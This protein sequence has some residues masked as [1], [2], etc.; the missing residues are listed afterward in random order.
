MTGDQSSQF[1]EHLRQARHLKSAFAG[2]IT[3]VGAVDQAQ[4]NFQRDL[5]SASYA[6]LWEFTDLSASEFADEVARFYEYEHAALQDMLSATPLA[7]SF[8]QRFLRKTLV[9]PYKGA[10]KTIVLAM[11]DPTDLAARRAADEIVLGPRIEIKVA[12]NVA[13][14]SANAGGS[15][16]SK[17]SN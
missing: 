14:A 10:D 6:K 15:A 9:F 11:A 16:C 8:S 12:S 7:A 4:G 13:G 5:H 17:Y 2:E 3:D 1:V